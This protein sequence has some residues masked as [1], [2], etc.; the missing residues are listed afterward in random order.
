MKFLLYSLVK[1]CNISYGYYYEKQKV[2]TLPISHF[3]C[4]HLGFVHPVLS[5]IPRTEISP[6][7]LLIRPKLNLEVLAFFSAELSIKHLLDITT[8]YK[9]SFLQIFSQF[10]SNRMIFG[11]LI[12]YLAHTIVRPMYLY[13][14]PKCT[15]CH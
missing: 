6:S 9:H 1:L 12:R 5:I 2:D 8:F 7:D 3:A 11:F 14:T 4:Q 15:G 10:I 13:L